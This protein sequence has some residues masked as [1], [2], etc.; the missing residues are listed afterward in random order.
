MCAWGTFNNLSYLNLYVKWIFCACSCYLGLIPPLVLFDKLPRKLKVCKAACYH[1]TWCWWWSMTKCGPEQGLNLWTFNHEVTALPAV[2]PTPKQ[3]NPNTGY[4]N[5]QLGLTQKERNRL[6]PMAVT[7]KNRSYLWC[8]ISF[9]VNK[10]PW[11]CIGHLRYTFWPC[12]LSDGWYPINHPS[13][14]TDLHCSTWQYSQR[15]MARGSSH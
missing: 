8:L 1:G 2:S 12:F 10:Y 13:Q 6:R 14:A 3:D 7:R 11:C 5:K 9:S 4:W 15:A